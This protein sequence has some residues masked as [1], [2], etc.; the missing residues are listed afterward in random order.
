MPHPLETNL[1]SVRSRIAA[2]A[3]RAGRGADS[4]ALVA[5]TK[6]VA[7]A[8][9][10]QLCRLGQRDL[11]ESR[12]SEL[13]RK[14]DHLRALGL[15][16]RWH[17]V[18]HL[19]GN[20]VRR[21]VARAAAIHSIDSLRLL[22]AVDRVAENLEARPQVWIQVKLT[23]E[24]AKSGLD[25]REVPG[26]VARAATLEHVSL[27]GL[28]TLAP[29]VGASERDTAARDVFRRLARLAREVAQER[30]MG[31]AWKLGTMR[32]SM[33]MSG[34]FE[35]AIEEGSDLVRIGSLLFEGLGTLG[36]EAG[37]A[38]QGPA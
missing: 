27:A 18:G 17:F 24:P 38:G 3:L 15:E 4:I 37:P 2:A 14:D 35:T 21:V 29:L 12:V 32:T 13:E 10:A 34:D 16:P 23:D 1:A 5:V 19:Q 22:E 11:G 6:S 9:A 26:L 8:V 28:M 30:L 7:P 31:D 33:G 25:P 20:K 36:R